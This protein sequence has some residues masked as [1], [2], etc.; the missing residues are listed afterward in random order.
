MERNDDGVSSP[1]EASL[2]GGNRPTCT[3]TELPALRQ[4]LAGGRAVAF[5]FD[6]PYRQFLGLWRL[7]RRICDLD[8]GQKAGCRMKCPAG[9][10]GTAVATASWPSL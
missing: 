6:R 10:A 8:R 4:P 2:F 9:A 1:A 5:Q 7:R 3:A